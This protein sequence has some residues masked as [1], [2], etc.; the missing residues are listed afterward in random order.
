M[1]KLEVIKITPK[2]RHQ[3]HW[4]Y[5]DDIFRIVKV[6]ENHGYQ[7]SESD[8][9]CVWELYSSKYAAGWLCLPES[10]E[11]IYNEIRDYFEEVE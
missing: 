9:I 7:I 3:Y 1:K 5:T 6:F 8:V 11:Y 4:E 10:D 2:I